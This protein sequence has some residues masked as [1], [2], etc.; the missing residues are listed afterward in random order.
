[1]G[2]SY[3]DIIN[4]LARA[5]TFNQSIKLEINGD[6]ELFFCRPQ[7]LTNEHV[8]VDYHE[9]TEQVNLSDITKIIIGC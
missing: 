4:I 8:I 7:K 3:S 1:M 9:Y 2:M 5:V 6:M